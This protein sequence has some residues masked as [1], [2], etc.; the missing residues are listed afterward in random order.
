MQQAAEYDVPAGGMVFKHVLSDQKAQL[1][2]KYSEN[3]QFDA[4]HSESMQFNAKH[5][6]QYKNAENTRIAER[7]GYFYARRKTA[8]KNSQ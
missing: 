5:V 8:D 6:V 1:N 2:A 3:A 4:K 7:N